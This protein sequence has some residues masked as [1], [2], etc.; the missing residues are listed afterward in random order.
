MRYP[1]NLIPAA[2]GGYVVSFPD[3]PEALTQGETRHQTLEAAQEALISAFEFYF[4]DNDPI[5]LPSPVGKT[6]D[7]VEIP[8]SVASKV[9]LLNAFLEARISQLELAKRIGRP[10]QEI[11][12]LFDLRHATKID[13]V[14]AAARAL[15]K[16]L[17]LTIK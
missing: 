5:P 14:Q 15:G 3:I 12:R 6:D 17:S 1:V 13:A 2:E 10:K 4:E 8:L 16:E 7:Y 11:T 9:L